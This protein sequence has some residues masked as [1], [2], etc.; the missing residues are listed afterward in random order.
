M[1]ILF[2]NLHLYIVILLRIIDHIFIIP[3]LHWIDRF[4]LPLAIIIFI[5]IYSLREFISRGHRFII[6]IVITYFISGLIHLPRTVSEWGN[7]WVGGSKES[8][9]EIVCTINKS[10]HIMY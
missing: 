8:Q 3:I 10:L 6:I 2:W 9:N 5:S 4:S 7:E 1:Q